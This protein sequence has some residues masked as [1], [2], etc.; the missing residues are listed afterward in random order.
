VFICA[1]CF[2]MR[3]YPPNPN[4]HPIGDEQLLG[5]SDFSG[6]ISGSFAS[7]AKYALGDPQ[8]QC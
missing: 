7:R 4:Q 5:G 8:D 3:P 6:Y 2:H 1:P